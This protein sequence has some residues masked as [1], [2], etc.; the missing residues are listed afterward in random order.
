M[1]LISTPLPG[2]QILRPLVLGDDRGV[3]VKS[4]HEQQLANFGISMTVREEFYSFSSSGVLRGMHFQVP[5]HAHQKLIY[6]IAGSVCDVV[7][8]IRLGSPTYGHYASF[9]LSAE[10][11]HIVYIPVGFAHGF[12]SME[13]DSCLIYKTDCVYAAE[14][15]RGIHWDSF[16]FEWPINGAMPK[17]SPRDHCHPSFEKFDSPF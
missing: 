9:E 10:N 13:D 1:Q 8:D 6:C 12:L 2:I 5:P 16:G 3:F 7:L 14:Y 17:I 4:F 11:R 15:D